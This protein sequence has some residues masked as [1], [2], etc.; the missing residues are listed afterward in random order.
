MG[1]PKPMVVMKMN[2]ESGGALDVA[3]LDMDPEAPAPPE[4]A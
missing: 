4:D 3:V 2:A 1:V